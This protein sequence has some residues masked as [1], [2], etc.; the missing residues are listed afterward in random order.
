ME[1]VLLPGTIFLAEMCVVTLGTLRIIFVSRGQKFLAP[2]LGFFEI[3]IWL[4]AISQVM[5]HLQNVWCFLAF[6]AGFTIGNFLGILIEKALAMGL[7]QVS[8]VAP[9]GAEDLVAELRAH[10]FGVTSVAGSGAQG[11]V[12]IV[13]TVVRRRQL[14]QVLSLVEAKQP[15]AFYAV[16]EVTA[17]SDGIFPLGER[18]L[19]IVPAA[20][21]A[22][23]QRGSEKNERTLE[24]VS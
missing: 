19:K 14:K 24:Q 2:C 1:A 6:A 10:D 17:V 4:F 3:I 16:D 18:G 21:R 8:I 9:Y 15:G 5:Q 22:M 11:P 7:A 23:M 12:Q 13:F 20:L